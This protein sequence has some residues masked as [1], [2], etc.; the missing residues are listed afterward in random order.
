M[1]LKELRIPIAFDPTVPE[2][3]SVQRTNRVDSPRPEGLTRQGFVGAGEIPSTATIGWLC[4]CPYSGL[5]GYMTI[6]SQRSNPLQP[7]PLCA[8]S[9]QVEQERGITSEWPQNDNSI[10]VLP[11]GWTDFLG[12]VSSVSERLRFG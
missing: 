10:S 1:Y 2:A 3:S 8:Q 9:W 7:C 4:C 11:R 12:L 5:T 6:L